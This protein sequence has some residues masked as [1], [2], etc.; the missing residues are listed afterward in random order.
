MPR[1]PTMSPLPITSIPPTAE[2]FPPRRDPN[3]AN[4]LLLV[5]SANDKNLGTNPVT[6]EWA[7]RRDRTNL[8][9]MRSYY[10]QPFGTFAGELPGGLTL[11]AGY[12][13]N[14]RTMFVKGLG[15]AIVCLIVITE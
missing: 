5:W 15:A 2:L 1:T 9:V 11:A 8:L 10:R 14:L 7:E 12:G 4:S 3:K 13:V 6:L